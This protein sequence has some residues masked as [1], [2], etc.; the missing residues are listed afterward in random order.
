ME[1]TRMTCIV[2]KW[3]VQGHTEVIRG[4]EVYK[5]NILKCMTHH[6][7]KKDFV[8]FFQDRRSHHLK[9]L[10]I[11]P[12]TVSAWRHM[13]S[14][15]ECSVPAEHERGLNEQ[16]VSL[17]FIRLERVQN[18]PLTVRGMTNKR[19]TV[20]LITSRKKCACP[21]KLVSRNHRERTLRNSFHPT[22]KSH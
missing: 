13:C 5:F 14:T 3:C 19:C 22:R 15:W 7:R 18:V 2:N 4:S 21:A 20:V 6:H 12:T 1:F 17:V 16:C 10:L 8:C 9:F 11:C